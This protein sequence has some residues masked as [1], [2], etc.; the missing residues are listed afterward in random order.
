MLWLRLPG[1]KYGGEFN[2]RLFV[3]QLVSID[4]VAEQKIDFLRDGPDRA[5]IKQFL[6]DTVKDFVS[7]L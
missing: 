1:K 7:P 3:G 2:D 6:A 5:T 4:D